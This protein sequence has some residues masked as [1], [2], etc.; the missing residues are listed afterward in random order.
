MVVLGPKCPACNQKASKATNIG[1]FKA[2][3][4]FTGQTEDEREHCVSG[5]TVGTD[6]Y[7]FPEQG[8][9]KWVYLNVEVTALP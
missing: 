7:T 8:T 2:S 5:Q 3:F 1:F 4:T 9:T 6:Y